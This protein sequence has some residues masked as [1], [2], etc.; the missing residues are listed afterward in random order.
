MKVKP[1][2]KCKSKNVVITTEYSSGSIFARCPDCKQVD[3]LFK[4]KLPC[5]ADSII[6]EWNEYVKSVK[7]QE[8]S[9]ND[10][11]TFKEE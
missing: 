1:C 11:L 4:V 10:K 3:Y 6:K 5:P 8:K 9:M 7:S 2:P